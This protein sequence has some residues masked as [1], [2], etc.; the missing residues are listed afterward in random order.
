ME[1][2]EKIGQVNGDDVNLRLEFTN[3]KSI[4]KWAEIEATYMKALYKK[5]ESGSGHQELIICLLQSKQY[6]NSNTRTFNVANFA[7]S[8]LDNVRTIN[9]AMNNRR[10]LMKMKVTNPYK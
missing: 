10:N 8:C 1:N 4:L 5:L 3:L 7:Q 2:A 9:I 6:N